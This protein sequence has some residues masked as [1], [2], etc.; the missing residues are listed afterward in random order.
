MLAALDARTYPSGDYAFSTGPLPGFVEPADVPDTWPA[1]APGDSGA[2]WRVWLMDQQ[3]DRRDGYRRNL[4]YADEVVAREL[5]GEAARLQI[6]FNPEFQ[7]LTLHG[8]DLRRDGGWLL[9]AG[10][11]FA[12]FKWQ[13]TKLY[14]RGV[15]ELVLWQMGA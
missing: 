10:A 4:D 2:R 7:K 5:L 15:V 1:D 3:I 14:A 8:V 9:L 13:A 6:D 11:L 12:G